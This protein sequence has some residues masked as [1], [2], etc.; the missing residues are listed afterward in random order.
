MSDDPR[1]LAVQLRRWRRLPLWILAATLAIAAVATALDW[2][3]PLQAA[4]SSLVLVLALG[5][6]WLAQ[7][8]IETLLAAEV[9]R[10]KEAEQEA[11]SANQTKSDFLT[12]MSHELRTPLG[13]IIGSADLLLGTELSA[14][15]RHHVEVIDSSAEALLTLIDDILDFAKLE[16]GRLRLAA[17]DFRLRELVEGV[18]QVVAPAAAAKDLELTVDVDADLPDALRGDPTRVRQILV[19]LASNAVKFTFEG[20]VTIRAE[21]T[22]PAAGEPRFR[23]AVHDTGIGISP[24]KQRRIFETFFQAE[25][26]SARRFGGSG[27]GLA[28]SKELVRRMGG[29]I[30]VESERGKGS[31]FWFELPLEPARAEVPDTVEVSLPITAAVDRGRF[32]ILVVDDDATNRR[33]ALA[34]LKA[35]GYRAKAVENGQAALDRLTVLET[36]D[37]VLMDC[38]M[39]E[40][41]GYETARRWRRS[42]TEQAAARTPIIAVTAHVLP[43]EREKCLAVGMDDYL[44][45]PYRGRDLQSALDRWLVGE[46]DEVEQKSSA[47]TEPSA[48]KEP[49]SFEERIEALRRLGE[50]TGEDVLGPTLESF[51]GEAAGLVEEMHAA[52]DAGEAGALGNAAHRLIS[53]SGMLG[54]DRL[55]ELLREIEALALE[56][57]LT[58]VEA[59]LKTAESAVKSFVQK[60][61]TVRR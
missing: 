23:L 61:Q 22:T 8:R 40:L 42:E 48:D 13:A 53:I 34:H 37:A 31:T 52:L 49:S 25:T 38:Q 33:L 41:D 9:E 4:I 17:Y 35:L 18:R 5:G 56:G 39:P 19:N 15:D 32:Q 1:A 36:F 16:A 54:A 51:P 50:A 47:D 2:I 21:R 27:L 60:L 29:E 20:R 46:P 28:I 10:R 57:E 12:N 58:N 6:T 11:R 7:R 3:S 55:V 43:G 59:V 26:I 45:K 44:S 14:E 30:G 24:E